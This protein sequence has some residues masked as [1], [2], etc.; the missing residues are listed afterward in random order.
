MFNFHQLIQWG[1]GTQQ[2]PN[3]KEVP[4]FQQKLKDQQ[5]ATHNLLYVQHLY[6]DQ[7]IRKI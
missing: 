7:L 2:K 5:G 6:I 4:I 3:G 1:K